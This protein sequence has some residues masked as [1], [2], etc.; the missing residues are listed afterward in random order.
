MR[1]VE[2]TRTSVRR[3]RCSS[4]ARQQRGLVTGMAHTH[5]RERAHFVR[6]MFSRIARRYDL[7]NTLMTGGMDRGWRDAAVDAADPPVRGR[8]LDVGTGT[9]GLALALAKRITEGR[10][11]GVD[12][13]EPM[14]RS[15]HVRLRR[16]H[17]GG[18]V[19]L[20]L[21]DVLE[22]PLDADVFDC[23]ATAFTVRNVPDVIEAFAEMRRVLRPGGRLVC[24]EITRPRTILGPLFALYFRHVVPLVGRLVAGDAEAYRYLPESAY[25]FLD[26]PHLAGA[27]RSA[28]LVNVRYRF[29][30]MGTVALHVGEKPL[31]ADRRSTTTS[32]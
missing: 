30:G 31:R 3:P 15:G 8:A 20:L 21:A 5:G 26:A 9:A 16:S 11:V 17:Y 10:V 18:R 4:P 1:R 29:L 27:M 32:K 6:S 2:A 25:A 24:L 12:F 7:M 14:L 23:A 22:L 13:A 28:G 19:Q